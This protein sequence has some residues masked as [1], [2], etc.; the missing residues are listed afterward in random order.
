MQNKGSRMQGVAMVG[1]SAMAVLFAAGSA[2]AATPGFY[3]AG[4][5]GQSN[6]NSDTW[7]AVRMGQIMGNAWADS[8][9][10][11]AW[12]EGETDKTDQGFEISVGYQFSPNLAI[13]GAYIDLGNFSYD[14]PLE[15]SD[16][17]TVFLD[18]TSAISGRRRGP[19]LSLVS[20][21]PAA[22]SVWLDAR[23]GVFFGRSVAK[24]SFGLEGESPSHAKFTDRKTAIFVGAG[25]N[26]SFLEKASIRLGYS[27][28]GKDAMIYH[29]VD[30][31]SLGVRVSL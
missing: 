10:I 7:T 28:F 12:S 11:L 24:V 25:L 1:A 31:I 9:N 5:F 2:G 27:R 13:E 8:Q 14:S 15:V 26:W 19:A 17:G 16:D 23:A 3:I 30:R 18:A 20:T 21:W 6:S 29:E 22:G 4:Q